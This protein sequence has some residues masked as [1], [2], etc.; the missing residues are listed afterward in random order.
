MVPPPSQTHMGAQRCQSS[1]ERCLPWHTC[2]GHGQRDRQHVCH[3]TAVSQGQARPGRQQQQQ[4]HPKIPVSVGKKGDHLAK[5]Q[6]GKCGP[7]HP[8]QGK[9]ILGENSEPQHQKYLRFCSGG[10]THTLLSAPSSTSPAVLSHL[11][12]RPPQLSG[13]LTQLCPFCLPVRPAACLRQHAA[14]HHRLHG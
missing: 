5:S 8:D 7:A 10:C 4:S 3:G 9:G 1:S 12:P 6:A 13:P 11:S 2:C 14:Q